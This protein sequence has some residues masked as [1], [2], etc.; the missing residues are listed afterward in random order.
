MID[1]RE[2]DT[3]RASRGR[4]CGTASSE[5]IRRGRRLRRRTV[6]VKVAGAAGA[7]A[8]V[9]VVVVAFTGGSRP[10]YQVRFADGAAPELKRTPDGGFPHVLIRGWQ[11]DRADDQS[12]PLDDS[13]LFHSAETTFGR[14]DTRVTL[15]MTEGD[16]S[17][18]DGLL[19][20][21][22]QSGDGQQ[23]QR[24]VLGRY[25]ATVTYYKGSNQ[26]SAIWFADQVVYE[27]VLDTGRRDDYFDALEALRIVDDDAWEAA[28]PDSGVTPA[29][30]GAVVDQ[31]LSDIPL[32]PGFDVAPL[33]QSNVVTDRT[34]LAVK[35]AGSA[36]CT[37][38]DRWLQARNDSDEA[39]AEEAMSAVGTSRN[40]QVFKDMQAIPA[41]AKDWD[42]HSDYPLQIWQY[43]DA[44]ASGKDF[45]GGRGISAEASA[46]IVC[47]LP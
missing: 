4:A 46:Q 3:L 33:R 40:W 41:T 45:P 44:M 8:A 42:H 24:T 37:W 25:P 20:D 13:R 39:A 31:I 34:Q 19:D 7:L 38:I 11:V 35:V 28:M 18:R 27:L 47:D 16:T 6:A 2:L 9:V 43:A 29:A 26:M 14:R 5:I 12:R 21:R 30:R 22:A 10:G 1:E 23:S 32:P 17:V 15:H 36:A